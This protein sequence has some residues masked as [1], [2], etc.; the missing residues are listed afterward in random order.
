M[1]TRRLWIMCDPDLLRVLFLNLLENE[2]AS[3]CLGLAHQTFSRVELG[4]DE[5]ECA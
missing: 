2:V 1:L 3:L 4:V 5:E